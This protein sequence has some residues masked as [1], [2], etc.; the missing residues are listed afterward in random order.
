M[1]DEHEG[2]GCLHKKVFGLPLPVV[3]IG[4]GLVAFFVLAHRGAGGGAAAAPETG[5]AGL[6]G[7]TGSG[8]AASL[9]DQYQ[10]EQLGY[11]TAL[12]Q[13]NLEAARF[14]LT[15]QEQGAAAFGSP[16]S[17]VAQGK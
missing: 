14:G 10:Q 5:P 2:G 6:T 15:Q 12:D 13:L 9:Q 7:D 16:G 4:G 11:Q 1:A 17:P 8:T 3:L